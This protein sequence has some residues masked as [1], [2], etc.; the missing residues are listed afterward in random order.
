MD[1]AWWLPPRGLGNG[2]D[3]VGWAQIMDADVALVAPVLEALHSEGIPGYA[4]PAVSATK[5]RPA[6][7]GRQRYRI[8]VGTSYNSRAEDALMRVLPRLADPSAADKAVGV[9]R[10]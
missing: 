8:W 10:G 9:R 5:R 2:L 1:R 3:D 6:R 4:A 7:G